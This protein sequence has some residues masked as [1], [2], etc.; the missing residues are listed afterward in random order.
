MFTVIIPARYASTRLPGKPLAD[1]HGKP[2][3]VRVMEQAIKSGASRVIIATDHTDV[4]AAVI[5]AGGEACMTNPDHQS[6]TE[7][8]AEVIDTYG[9]SDDEI[10]VNVQGDEP[11]I[12]PEIIRQ[13]AQNLQGSQA[14]M[15]TLAVP[16]H[17]AQ[18]AFNPNAVKVVMD[19]DGYAL[20]FSRATIPWD[21][22]QFAKS[23]ETIGD[24]FLRHIGIYAYRA[25]FIRRYIAWDASPL[26]KI[27][28]LEQL[29]VLW[30]GEKIHVAVAEK[31]PGAGVD[32]PEDLELVRQ[33]FQ[34]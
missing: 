9:F 7:R 15:G 18:E 27:E 17:S 23:K 8:L 2:M 1:I 3:V 14:N 22:D 11:L 21:R 4:A 30:Y 13:V 25:G 34:P 16:I 29:R 10:I 31:A 19:K 20:Y 32:T 28:M 24:T 5:A 6:G 33:E 12:P 26:E